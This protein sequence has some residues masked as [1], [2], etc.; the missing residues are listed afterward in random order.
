MADETPREGA[1]SLTLDPVA[2]VVDPRPQEDK[3]KA[4]L[5]LAAPESVARQNERRYA[6]WTWL[7]SQG[8]LYDG[9][10]PGGEVIISPMTAAEEKILT[11]QGKDRME[12]ID[13]IIKR[14]LLGLPVS[15]EDLLLP[16]VFYL[17]LAIRN[18]TYGS[19]YKFNV[20]CPACGQDHLSKVELPTGL[21]LRCLSAEDDCEPYS[22]TLRKS[23]D[24]VTFRLLRVRD[25]KEIRKYSRAQYS[26]SVQ[27]GDP[28]Y[29]FRLSLQLVNVNGKELNAV[30][31]LD[32]VESLH[33]TDSLSF[34]RAIEKRT[35]GPNLT[36][37]TC[38]PACGEE[39]EM[40]MPFDKEFFRP[41]D[42]GDKN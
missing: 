33:G 3:R 36:L 8:Y 9:K 27:E 14:C 37:A 18:I 1:I 2:E 30:K 29:L 39:G 12:I 35:F 38:C 28:A 7:P 24:E 11:I 21:D 26:R 5:I 4:P 42:D 10:F 22:T 31:K 40:R 20:K 17:L 23:G 32:Y 41:T 19:T 25:E 15:Y 6:F 34:R 13:T 16:D